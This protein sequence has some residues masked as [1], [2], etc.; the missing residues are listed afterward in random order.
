[1]R[2]ESVW[3]IERANEDDVALKSDKREK[4]R[5][6]YVIPEIPS[7]FHRLHILLESLKFPEKQHVNQLQ[8]LTNDFCGATHTNDEENMIHSKIK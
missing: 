4:R 5:S 3:K 2:T 8:S 6:I 7:T 1:M